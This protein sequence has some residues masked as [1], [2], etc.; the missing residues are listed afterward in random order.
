MVEFSFV[1]D[2]FLAGSFHM[3]A[4]YILAGRKL[5]AQWESVVLL[6][7]WQNSWADPIVQD[8]ITYPM[9]QTNYSDFEPFL[10]SR[11]RLYPRSMR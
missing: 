8:G 2:L 9:L 5:R 3:V 4:V 1:L 7:V 10:E 6:V 11:M